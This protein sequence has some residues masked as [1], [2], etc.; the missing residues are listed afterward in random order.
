MK[1]KKA[2]L[3]FCL[4]LF[5]FLLTLIAIGVHRWQIEQIIEEQEII[6]NRISDISMRQIDD[7]YEPSSSVCNWND[8]DG[9]IDT[10]HC[11]ELSK[12]FSALVGVA[13]IEY[14]SPKP[15]EKSKTIIEFNF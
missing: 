1:E 4:L 6:R 8:Y 12:L 10:F 14:V 2:I 3:A 13:D 7:F 9:T 11:I 15:A 5:M